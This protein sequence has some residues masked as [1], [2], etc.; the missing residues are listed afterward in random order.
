MIAMHLLLLLALFQAPPAPAAEPIRSGCSSDDPQIATAGSGETIQVV[1]ALAGDQE[2]C[3]HVVMY[4]SGQ[5]PVNGYVLGERLP[6][7]AVFVHRREKEAEESAKAEAQRARL[8]AAPR[9]P[10]GEETK[11]TDPSVSTQFPEFSGRDA[12]GKPVSLSGLKGRVTIVTFWSP[13]N[14]STFHQLSYMKSVYSELHNKGLAA[15]GV[16]MDPDPRHIDALDDF[17]PPWPQMPDR[18]GLASRYQ[19]D[20]RVGKTFILD[21]S[22]RIVAAGP[23]GPD[24]VKA[25]HELMDA[26]PATSAANQ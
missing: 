12:M 5:T 16:S 7:I 21:A 14:D 4:R 23:V 6:A 26:P 10:S 3:Y 22:H 15:I 2:T 24:L 18:S 19:V 8:A 1:T 17:T 11:S 9:K 13:K 25:I 20:P